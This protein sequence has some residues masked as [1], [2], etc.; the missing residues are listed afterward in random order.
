MNAM[1]TIIPDYLL[2]LGPVFSCL[3]DLVKASELYQYNRLIGQVKKARL[4]V[5]NVSKTFGH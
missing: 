4:F 5:M 3:S 1:Q 2:L